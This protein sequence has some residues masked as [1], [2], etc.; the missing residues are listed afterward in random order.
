NMNLFNSIDYQLLVLKLFLPKYDTVSPKVSAVTEAVFASG[1]I[2]PKDAYTLTSIS[3][4]FITRSLVEENDVVK[5]GQLLFTLDNRQQNTQV[6]I[7]ST[8]V[9]YANISANANSP[10]LLQIKAQIDAA[11]IKKTTDSNSLARLGRT[12]RSIR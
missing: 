3:D 11:R 12:G 5:D 1:T 7:A 2:D 8:N 10:Q 9:N 4:G 6:A